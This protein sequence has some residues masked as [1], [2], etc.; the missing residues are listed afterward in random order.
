MT[1]LF[2]E[3]EDGHTR[4][5]PDE[6]TPAQRPRRRRRR[7]RSGLVVL[8]LCL[9]LVLAAGWFGAGQIRSLVRSMGVADFPGPG[10][11]QVEVV[12][13]P[14]DTGSRI[15][16]R[17]EEAGVVASQ[18]AFVNALTSKPGDDVQPGTYQ[19]RREMKATD[20]LSLLRSQNA[21][22]SLQIRVREGLWKAETYAIIGKETGFTPAQLDAA[23]ASPTVGL[24]P[25]AGGDPE[26]YLYPATYTFDPDVTPEQV[27]KAMVG[28]YQAEITAAGV[29]ADKQRETL[30]KASLVQ[31]EASN[32]DDFPK[33][34]RVIENRLA[35]G[36]P[37]GLDTTVNFAVQKRGFDLTQADLAKDT[38][39]NTRKHAGLPP[40]PIN[41][42]GAQA[43]EAAAHPA[44][45]D[46]LYFVTV[47]ADTGETVFTSDYNEFLAAKRQWE[48]WYAQNKDG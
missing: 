43:I 7:R 23:A 15:G 1:D 21:R 47:N 4:L 42:P 24:P 39:Y 28:K 11:G 17:L 44:E 29:P 6:V 33:V 10:S 25:E 35:L 34:A 9:A 14:G 46:W 45:G 31:A 8:L 27:L 2:D 12:I 30:I 22:V 5:A 19:L 13:Q 20:A 36:Q 32:P 40:G 3:D 16:T 48:S 26:G 41:S 37:L 38:P 18:R